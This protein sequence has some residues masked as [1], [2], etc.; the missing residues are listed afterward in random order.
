MTNEER[1][2][3][4]CKRMIRLIDMGA[5]P[6]IVVNELV[7]IQK[8]VNRLYP[9]EMDRRGFVTDASTEE[10]TEDVEDPDSPPT[11]PFGTATGPLAG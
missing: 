8:Q 9:D 6:V 10:I 5:P 7:L 1:L 11:L 2:V 4:C 3:N